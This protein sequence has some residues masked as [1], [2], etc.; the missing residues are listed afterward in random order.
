MRFQNNN[1]L[2]KIILL[3]NNRQR[4]VFQ[5]DGRTTQTIRASKIS[6]IGYRPFMVN[7][8]IVGFLYSF[9][10]PFSFKK[11]DSHVIETFNIVSPILSNQ[12]APWVELL[13]S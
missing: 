7:F 5:L 8:L 12:M 2:K 11:F 6:H 10:E 13:D 1:F 9:F 3:V 4:T